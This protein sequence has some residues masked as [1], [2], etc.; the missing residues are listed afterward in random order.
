[1]ILDTVLDGGALR[2]C[3]MIISWSEGTPEANMD[4]QILIELRAMSWR[5]TRGGWHERT[6]F[7]HY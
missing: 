1:M 7:L 3:V 4:E 5:S 2:G 6:L